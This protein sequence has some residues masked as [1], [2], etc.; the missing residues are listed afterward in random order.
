MDR[1]DL[2]A[3]NQFSE[4]PYHHP[5]QV[6]LQGEVAR[7]GPQHNNMGAADYR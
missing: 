3:L 2:P 4:T 5:G 7:V 1:A 6:L